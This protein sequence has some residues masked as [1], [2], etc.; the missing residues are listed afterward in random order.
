MASSIEFS[1]C[2]LYKDKNF[3]WSLFIMGLILC[4]ASVSAAPYKH[5]NY[6]CVIMRRPAKAL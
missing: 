3:C 1:R 6:M 5:F 4:C 2:G